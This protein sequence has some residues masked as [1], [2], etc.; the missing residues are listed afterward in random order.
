MQGSPPQSSLTPH[1]AIV[2]L[3][4]KGKRYRCIN[5]YAIVDAGFGMHEILHLPSLSQFGCQEHVG[6]TSGS[7]PFCGSFIV[8]FP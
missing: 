5:H 7:P 6:E 8:M 1:R 2:S 3:Q 4:M